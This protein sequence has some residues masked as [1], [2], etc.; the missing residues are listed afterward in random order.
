MEKGQLARLALAPAPS[1]RRETRP[2]TPLFIGIPN[3]SSLARHSARSLSQPPAP[4]APRAFPP[5]A[6]ARAAARRSFPPA[7]VGEG[8]DVPFNPEFP[9]LSLIC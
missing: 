6:G 7:E 2:R 8:G 4:T 3:R 5:G 9:E 1:A